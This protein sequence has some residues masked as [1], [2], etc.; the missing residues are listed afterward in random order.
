MDVWESQH[1]SAL[2]YLLQCIESN[3]SNPNVSSRLLIQC[4]ESYSKDFLKF[5]ALDPANANS[6]K[7]L[8]SGEVELGGVINK[9][10]EQFIQ[11]SLT[12]STQL[13]LDEIQCASLLQRGIEA[14]QNLD[15]TPVQ[16]ALYFFFL[17]REQLLECLESLTRVVGLKDLESDISTAL[18]SYLQSLCENG[19]NLVKTCI[20]TIPILDNKVSEIL[21]S[22][23]GGQIL[24]VS[25]VVDFQEFIRL[26]H[27]A[28]VAELETISVILY[29]LAKVDLFQNSHFESLL[30][31]LRKYDSPNKN[32]VLILPTLYAFIDKVLEVEY[33]PDQKVQ[34]R[35]NSVEILQKIH[36]A[37]I[38]SPSQDWRSSQFKN[39][40]GIWWVTR[41][42]ATCKQ[43]EKVP[44]F[45]DYET[46]IK[47]PANEIIQNG[48]FSDMITLLVYPFRQSET[49]GMEWAFAF[50]SRSRITVNWSLIRPFIASIIFS[51][52][53]SFAQAFVSYM[54]D[55][56]KTLRLL[57][58]DRYL[59]NT[60]YPTSIPGEQIEEYFPFEEFYYLLSSI[61]TYNVSWISD[62]WDDIESDMYGFLTWSMGSQIPGIITAFTLLLAS[63]CKN[64]TSASKIY[65]L[66]SE[67]IPEVGHLESLMITSP[68][69]SYIFNVFRYYISH[70]KP[71]QTVVT[72]SGLARVHTDPSEIDTDSALILQ[73]YILLFSSVVRQDAQIASTFCEN[74]DLNPIATLFELLECRL[75]DSVRICIV[76]A[77]ESL[78]HL[79]TGSFNNALW[80]A[81]DNWFVS[82]VLFDVDGGLAPM[83]IPAI[84]KR[85]LTKPVT[86]CGPL[87]NNI[88]RLTVNLE[89][90]ISFVNLLTSLTRNKSELNVNLTFPE[91]LGASYRTPGVQPYVDYVVETFVASSTQW[92]LMRDVGSIRLQYACLQ[93]MLAVLDGLN[94]DLL[95]YSRILSSKVRDNLQNNNL[96][97]YLTRHPA[98]SLLEA[99]YTESVYSGLFDLVEYGFDQ[100]ED[101]S[102][103]KTIV[104]T[105]SAS[106][107]ILRN[108]LSLQRVLF[109]NVV[110]YIAELGISKYILDL[111]ISRRAYKEV[112]MTRI[113]SIVHLALLVGSR[114][115]C[116]LRSAIEILSYLVDAEG[117]MNK[118]NPDENKLLCSIIRTAN[119]SKRIIFGF[120]RTFESQFLTLL[121]TN[122]ESSLILKLLLNN[123]KQSG[124]VY[125]LALLILGFDIS[126]TNVITLR[127]QPGYVGSRVS[128][129]NSLL[130]FIEGRTIVNGI[131]ETPVIM[132]Q[133]LEI[134]A[135]LCSCPLTSEVTLS[136]IRARPG[137]LVK[138]VDGEPILTQQVIQ[139]LG[140]F[141]S[142]EVSMVSRCIRSRTQIMNMLATEIHYAASV[143]Q[144]KYLNEYVASLIRTNEKTH[145]TELSQKESGFKILEFMDILR[146]DPQSI[147]FE[148]PNIPGF[149][150]NMFIT[151]F[152]RGHSDFQFDTERVLKI[153]R[154]FFEAEM[155]NLGGSAE[156]K[157]SWLE[158]Q[159]SKLKELAQRL[160][161]FNAHVVLLQDIHGCL[162][163]WARLTGL[164]VDDCN[165]VISDVHFDDFIWEVLRLVLPGVTVHNLGTQGT[166]S[167]TSSVIETILPHAL[168][169]IGALKPEELGKST[170]FMEGIHDVIV[171]L[172]KGIQCQQSDESI[173]EN[174]Y[175]SLLSILTVFQK[176]TSANG[177]D[178]V[179]PVFKDAFQKLITPNLLTS[180]FFD[181]LTKDALYTNGSCWELSVII[182]NF[183]HHVSPDI[184][185]HLYKYYLRRNFVS[186]FIDAFSRAFSELLSSNKDVLEVLSGLEAGQCLLITFAQNKLTVHSVLTFDYIKL[187]V[188]ML[189][190]LCKQGGIQYLKPP[191]QRLMIQLLQIFIL[192]LMRVTLKEISNK[193]KLLLQS[194]FLLSRKLQ[195][196]VQTGADQALSPEMNTVKKYVETISRLLDLYRE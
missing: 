174:L 41:L 161:T 142:E 119:E 79:S 39:I 67:P 152:D 85:S 4:L 154:L 130:D 134:V 24:G 63:L 124:G 120:I 31:M 187:M 89:M 192:V 189:L 17:A 98:I 109:K 107:C 156:E 68:S 150:L 82:S 51:E 158:Q 87:L 71:V 74:Q 21:K 117:F 11:L 48:V 165:E 181:V 93:Y 128:L 80:T 157:Y 99:L 27:E 160:N 193:D 13:N 36:Q 106:L 19:N 170:Y 86:S 172:L 60:T 34:L 58:E 115:K 190:Q 96:H 103:P 168:R 135:F 73:A 131:W 78:A 62:F 81:L 76:R 3:P 196:S 90:K 144:N 195:D 46:T 97:V 166:V 177:G 40:L 15:R 57:E 12:L 155:A 104:I 5:L 105:V 23:A 101:V 171:G 112:F 118:R 141:S 44:S 185:T 111:T 132:V 149:N 37:I 110:P 159:N 55:I 95:L 148:L 129:M 69:W 77:L 20:D 186:S 16:A 151:R 191:V 88:R 113:S 50:K 94:I 61:Y 114:H 175:G 140:G 6:R 10:N 100:L 33:L 75:P 53:R 47:N 7:K 43:I 54:P 182:L 137:L 65:E 66:F 35:S 188:Q 133:A 122:D 2:L 167:V 52:L 179:D 143:G 45:I 123:L 162:T 126:S 72:S 164:L 18:K 108:V 28:H 56:L 127:D 180:Q 25:E 136:V 146:I 139:N 22:E 30:V 1:F 163:A 153:Y 32:A 145:S 14:S 49:E 26:S 102:V 116:F 176:H 83:S 178:K 91:N 147:T 29:Q 84:S 121:S 42:N 169:R 92:R 184:S 194:I 64:T 38:Q 138:M 59:T 173:R 9:V 125:S 70:L 183:L 8:E